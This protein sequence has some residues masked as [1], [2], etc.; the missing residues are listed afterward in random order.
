MID[1]HL[2]QEKRR[3]A[4]N[5]GQRVVEIKRHRARQLQCA[6]EFLL[7]RQTEFSALGSR[8]AGGDSQLLAFGIARRSGGEVGE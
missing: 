3:V 8:V 7:L 4:E 2:A 1:F 6:I 5:T